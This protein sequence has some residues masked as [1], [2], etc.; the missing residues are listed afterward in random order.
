MGGGPGNQPPAEPALDL[1]AP[2]NS[3]ISDGL[4]YTIDV[5]DW[6]SNPGDAATAIGNAVEDWQ[7]SGLNLDFDCGGTVD[8]T[9]EMRRGGGTVQGTTYF[10]FDSN[11]DLSSARIEIKGKF[12][13]TN[14]EPAQLAL[15][16]KHEFG[17]ALGLGHWNISGQLMSP[18][19]T[20]G[21][22]I[23]ACERDAVRDVQG[24]WL[25][26]G[27]AWDGTDPFVCDPN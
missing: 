2:W 21:V 1:I 18:Y 12:Q 16:A 26:G 7:T 6:V 8:V 20:P 24:E 15:I 5:P 10:S 27:S 3:N 4:C 9:I 22:G 13:G 25:S 14:N 11:G 17:H 23:S 19:L